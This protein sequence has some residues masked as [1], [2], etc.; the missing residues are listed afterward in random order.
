MDSDTDI[1]KLTDLVLNE[2]IN[3][4]QAKEELKE[5]LLRYKKN[6]NLFCEMFCQVIHQK[7]DMQPHEKY[8]FVFSIIMFRLIGTLQS[9][10]ILVLKGYYFESNILIRNFYETLGLCV[11]LKENPKKIDDWLDGKANLLKTVQAFQLARKMFYAPENKELDKLATKTYGQ[12]CNYVHG[13]ALVNF[14]T[15]V[16]IEGEEGNRKFS[17]QMPSPLRETEVMGL[18]D[19]SM[20]MLYAVFYVFEDALTNEQKKKLGKA[21]LKQLG[22]YSKQGDKDIQ[23]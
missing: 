1:I 10:R 5:P 23:D 20:A 13:N 3:E 9:I 12:L 17:Y 4:Q 19:L 15:V 2:K 8:K 18:G 6:L 14:F 21:M 16:K 22:A 7:W 11:F